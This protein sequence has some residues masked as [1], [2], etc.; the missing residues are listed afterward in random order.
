MDSNPSSRLSSQVGRT[1]SLHL[2]H[3]SS[4]RAK[5]CRSLPQGSGVE[6]SQAWQSLGTSPARLSP[7]HSANSLRLASA[8]RSNLSPADS[9]LDSLSS[10]PLSQV[11]KS[12]FE[13]SDSEQKFKIRNTETGEEIDLRDENKQ[14]FVAKLNQ[15]LQS[16]SDAL[17]H[18]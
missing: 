7:R 1:L 17:E 8:T 4:P 5:D 9:G 3:H 14:D 12:S 18:F 2:S 6:E 16:K 10:S 15:V 11:M 13:S